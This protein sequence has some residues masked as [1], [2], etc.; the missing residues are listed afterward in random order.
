MVNAIRVTRACCAFVL[1][2]ALV[3]DSFR[4]VPPVKVGPSDLVVKCLLS[5][6]LGIQS[7]SDIDVANPLVPTSQTDLGVGNTA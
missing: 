7:Q 1:G 4:S 2:F 5:A 6:G 3:G